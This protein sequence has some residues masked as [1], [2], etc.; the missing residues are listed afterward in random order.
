MKHEEGYFDGAHGAKTY[1]AAWLPDGEVKAVLVVVHGVAEHIGRYM[2]VVNHF[3]PK[4]YAV[5]GLDHYGHGKTAGVRAFVESFDDFIGPLKTYVNM[6]KGWQPGKPMFMIG[7]SMGGLITAT[8][9]TENQAGLKGAVLSGPAVK[10]GSDITPAVIAIGKILSAIAPKAGIMALDLTAISKD[11]AVIKA[12]AEDALVWHGKI[13]ARLGAS[14]LGA[15]QAL[16]QKAA[17][18]SL[19]VLFVQ[20]DKDRL[21]EPSGVEFL[22]GKISSKDKTIKV[23]PGLFHEVFNEPEREMVLGD[24]GAWL[25]K[26]L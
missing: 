2:N 22:A 7:H 23:Y 5:Y 14:M 8:Y 21:V 16:P 6:V 24:V 18:I 17:N 15:M 10:F 4:G 19:P 12:S 1:W 3:V 11:P 9:L 20:G 13:T 25:E 26:H